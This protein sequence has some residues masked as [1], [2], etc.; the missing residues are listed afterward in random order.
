MQIPMIIVLNMMDLAESHDIQIDEFAL[1]EQFGCSVV[2]ATAA[3]HKPSSCTA[4][5]NLNISPV[6][7][8]AI[9]IS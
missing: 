1:A 4:G 9:L 5:L 7:Y 3:N 8:L 2:T 6:V